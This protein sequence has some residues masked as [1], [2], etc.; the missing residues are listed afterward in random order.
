MQFFH[1]LAGSNELKVLFICILLDTFFGSIRAIKEKK[2]NSNVGI[3]GL[4]RKFA[5]VVSVIAFLGI[6]LIINFNVIG[7][8]PEDVRNFIKLNY[9]GISSLFLWLFIIYEFLSIIKNMI[10]CKLPIPKKLQAFLEKIFKEYTSE[11][12][13]EKKEN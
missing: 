9:V 4:I 1:I 5:M 11:L 8:I 13:E 10:K 12:D 6:D 2:L 7:F 3:D